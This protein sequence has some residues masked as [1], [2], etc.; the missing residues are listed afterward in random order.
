MRRALVILWV[1]L[2]CGG[3]LVPET[4][5]PAPPP[6]SQ[7]HSDSDCDPGDDCIGGACVGLSAGQA[8]AAV[9]EPDAGS[10]AGHD[11]GSPD[12]GHPDAGQPDAGHPDAGQPDAG[13][14]P[15]A[16]LTVSP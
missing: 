1:T 8:D 2:A 10:D 14:P 3:P 15:T 6:T 16:H 12:A 11:G 9:Q 5:P 4:A 13:P 7:C